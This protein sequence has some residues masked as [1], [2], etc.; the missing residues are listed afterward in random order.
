MYINNNT[1]F[2]YATHWF[3]EVNYHCPNLIPNHVE[4]EFLPK[5]LDESYK[6]TR[7]DLHHKNPWLVDNIMNT[8]NFTLHSK[9]VPVYVKYK[10]E[11]INHESLAHMWNE[12]YRQYYD[13]KFPKLIVRYEDLVFYA[14][15]VT[16]TACDCFGGTM[17]H[18]EF[19]YIGNSAKK[20]DIHMNKTSL[21][22]NMLKFAS[23]TV[24]VTKGMTEEDLDFAK[25]V[26]DKEMMDFF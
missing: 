10:K 24:N 5:A 14:E 9:T 16:T 21:I 15:E 20:G 8:A 19:Q 12:W 13:A 22:D 17:K 11:T 3:H 6:Y 2:S 26:L 1:K 23:G 25:V 7:E 4:H 18:K